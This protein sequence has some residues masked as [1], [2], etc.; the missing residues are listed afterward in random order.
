MISSEVA[1]F[2]KYVFLQE[3]FDDFFFLPLCDL[4]LMICYC[5]LGTA[6]REKEM[7]KKK[8]P[9]QKPLDFC[10]AFNLVSLD[11]GRQRNVTLQY[12]K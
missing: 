4:M 5:S 2:L 10:L 8:K 6:G 3:L 9:S 11:W 7:I 1:K 12:K